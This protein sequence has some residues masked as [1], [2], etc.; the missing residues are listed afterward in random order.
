MFPSRL[1]AIGDIHGCR[2]ALDALL[3]SLQLCDEDRLVFLG[4]Y[5]DRGPD[6]RGVLERLIELEA[7]GRHVFLRGNHEA[8]MLN[9]RV[10][11][12]WLQSWWEVGGM[13]TIASYDALTLKE[14]PEAHWAFLERTRL[15][16]ETQA[17]IFVHGASDEGPVETTP[18]YVLLWRRIHDIPPHP[19][20]KR[21][22]CGHTSQKS[23]RPLDRDF[24][25]C[26]DTFAHGDGWLTALEVSCDEVFQANDLGQTRQGSL[27]ELGKKSR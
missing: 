14:I 10:N 18:E 25:V 6:S 22:I 26:I 12:K 3:G 9:A 20:G 16:F 24:A 15:F 19:S 1:F 11:R 8:W 17:H 2:V 7:T 13:E 5:V 4:D 21:V 27:D 23:G